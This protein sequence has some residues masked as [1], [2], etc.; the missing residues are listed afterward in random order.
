MNANIVSFL[1]STLKQAICERKLSLL[2]DCL[3]EK[4]LH[5]KFSFWL[6]VILIRLIVSDGYG[7]TYAQ[8]QNPT[9][10][11]Q[12]IATR[13]CEAKIMCKNVPSLKCRLRM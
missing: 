13:I 6:P 11:D 8:S 3:T 9:M 4:P 1:S 10:Q 5:G 7:S 2:I 12:V